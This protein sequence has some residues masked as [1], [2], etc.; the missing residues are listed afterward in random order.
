MNRIW[1]YPPA[2]PSFEVM[3]GLWTLDFMDAVYVRVAGVHDGVDGTTR[4]GR[5]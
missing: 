2:I 4:G 1:A 3:S 5:V